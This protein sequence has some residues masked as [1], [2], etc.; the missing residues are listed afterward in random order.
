MNV[1][2]IARLEVNHD[3]TATRVDLHAGI[4]GNVRHDGDRPLSRYATRQVGNHR[5]GLRRGACRKQSQQ[6]CVQND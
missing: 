5:D 1:Y 4:G 6:Q 2:S 3:Q